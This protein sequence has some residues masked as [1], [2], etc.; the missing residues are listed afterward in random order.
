MEVASMD[1]EPT[2]LV[3]GCGR[4]LST[5]RFRLPATPAIERVLLRLDP[6]DGRCPAMWTSLTADEALILADA[7]IREARTISEGT[8]ADTADVPDTGTAADRHH[9]R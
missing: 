6:A 2:E 1:A 3:T 9:R 4:R 8:V 5:G 7:L